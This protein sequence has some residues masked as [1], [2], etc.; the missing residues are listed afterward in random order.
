MP[1]N[2]LR[3]FVETGNKFCPKEDEE[4][5]LS[6]RCPVCGE[7]CEHIFLGMDDQ[8]FGCERCVTKVRVY[9]YALS[10]WPEGGV[11]SD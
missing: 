4:M 1:N 2:E 11:V 5:T 3:S 9:D 6:S 7:P 8:A 10:Q